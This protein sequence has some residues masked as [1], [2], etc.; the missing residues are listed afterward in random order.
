VDLQKTA[1]T[2]VAIFEIE[3]QMAVRKTKTFQPVRPGTA[4]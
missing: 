1:R 3:E 4:A 2:V